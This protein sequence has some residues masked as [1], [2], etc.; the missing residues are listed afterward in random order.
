MRRAHAEQLFGLLLIRTPVLGVDST[1]RMGEWVGSSC[2]R[3]PPAKGQRTIAHVFQPTNATLGASSSYNS[4]LPM[5]ASSSSISASNSQPKLAPKPKEKPKP[6]PKPPPPA[7]KGEFTEEECENK[8][9]EEHLRG[10]HFQGHR[11]R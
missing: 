1:P 3:H 10:S 7:P 8:K 6:K 2:A 11:G 4:T 9:T 5:E